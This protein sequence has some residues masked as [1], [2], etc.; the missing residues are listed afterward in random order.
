MVQPKSP[1]K[2]RWSKRWLYANSHTKKG[3]WIT[4]IWRFKVTKLL[5][6]IKYCR[7]PVCL[8]SATQTFSTFS[9]KHF[10]CVILFS[11]SLSFFLICL[12]S[13]HGICLMV[14]HPIVGILIMAIWRFPK[15]GGTPKSFF[16]LIKIFPWDKPSNYWGTP[17]TAPGGALPWPRPPPTAPRTSKS[18][19]QSWQR[20]AHGRRWQKPPG[21]SGKNL[22]FK[23]VPT[24]NKKSDWIDF[25]NVCVCVCMCNSVIDIYI[26]IYIYIHTYI[27]T[28][29]STLTLQT[30][31]RFLWPCNHVSFAKAAVLHWCLI[32]IEA[33]LENA[34]RLEIKMQ[35]R[36]VKYH[37]SRLGWLWAIEEAW[38]LKM[39]AN[40]VPF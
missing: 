37:P 12:G 13:R 26:Y 36:S 40:G 16:F 28:N 10:S 33:P 1:L 24:R 35:I 3:H 7:I 29:H 2:H 27:Y 14:I 20:W 19:S 9:T 4:T 8:I 18:R 30:W 23:A 6:A 17:S 38:E 25:I 39:R 32:Q 34:S 21:P 31:P 22:G 11:L 15:M 5:L